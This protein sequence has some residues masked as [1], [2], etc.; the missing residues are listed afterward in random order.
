MNIKR[1]AVVAGA[2]VLAVVASTATAHAVDISA[3]TPYLSG[4]RIYATG[5]L[6]GPNPPTKVCVS[7]LASHPASPDVPIA[8]ECKTIYG[9]DVTASASN[10]CG[11]YTTFI[12][13]ERD[14]K[15][16]RVQKS[17]STAICH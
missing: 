10:F 6:Y 5:T 8:T 15:T 16:L 2:A 13:V 1:C 17:S 4:G 12:S 11:S 7:L 14:G 9:G 3:K